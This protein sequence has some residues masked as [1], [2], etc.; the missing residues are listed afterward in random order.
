MRL[1]LV[2]H[3][4]RAISAP[5]ALTA[6]V[7]SGCGASPPRDDQPF[8]IPERI[9][10]AKTP[11]AHE[12]LA[13][14]YDE[15]AALARAQADKHRAMKKSYELSPF[16]HRYQKGGHIAVMEP[17]CDSLIRNAEE[18]A[19]TYGEMAEEHRQLAKELGGARRD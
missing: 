14:Y 15:Q 4:G 18:A 7:L 16:A 1:P 8:A 2:I 9:E 11:A 19:K 6:A 5:L 17:H 10:A 3:A 12:D 13:N